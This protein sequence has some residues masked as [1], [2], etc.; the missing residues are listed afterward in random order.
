MTPVMTQT[1]LKEAQ[2]PIRMVTTIEKAGVHYQVFAGQWPAWSK[3]VPFKAKRG[4]RA[5][6]IAFQSAARE[7]AAFADELV[8]LV[9]LGEAIDHVFEASGEGARRF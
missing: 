7:Q 9:E 4:C 8:R 1:Q 3:Q 2:A 5:G 6:G